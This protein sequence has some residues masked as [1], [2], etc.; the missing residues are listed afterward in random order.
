MS[1]PTNRSREHQDR[2]HPDPKPHRSSDQA[3]RL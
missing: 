2:S 1:P 3:G